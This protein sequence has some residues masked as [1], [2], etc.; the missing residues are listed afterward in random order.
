MESVQT[1]GLQTLCSILVS[2]AAT[3]GEQHYSSKGGEPWLA[4]KRGIV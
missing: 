3:L 1:Q 2:K 4:G